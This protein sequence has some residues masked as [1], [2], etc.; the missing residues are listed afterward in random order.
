MAGR[1]TRRFIHLYER[2]S[3]LVDLSPRSSSEAPEFESTAA[4]FRQKIR[5]DNIQPRCLH[6][7]EKDGEASPSRLGLD[8]I[9]VVSC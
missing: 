1:L 3:V 4:D 7:M 5:S 8:S 6:A 9:F 2:G